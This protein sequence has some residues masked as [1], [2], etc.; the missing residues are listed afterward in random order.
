MQGRTL[1]VGLL[2]SVARVA[3]AAETPVALAKPRPL[4]GGRG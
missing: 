1:L 4:T 3:T 2:L